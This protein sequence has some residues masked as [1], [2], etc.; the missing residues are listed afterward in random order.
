VC[1]V[2]VDFNSLCVKTGET[3]DRLR[4]EYD[5]GQEESECLICQKTDQGGEP[6]N[7][8]TLRVNQ[9]QIS[10]FDEGNGDV[11]VLLHGWIVTKESFVPMAEALSKRLRIIALDFPGFG[12]SE[13]LSV[14]HTMDKYVS[15]LE[16][17][18]GEIGVE[19][20]H[21]LG[22]S[23]GAAIAFKFALRNNSAVDRLI[24]QAPVFYWGQLSPFFTKGI[25]RNLFRLLGRLNPV[26]RRIKTS[27][28]K[29]LVEERIPR[30]KAHTSDP[31]WDV[32]EPLI[33]ALLTMY[34]EKMVLR[35]FAETA[36]DL[37]NTDLRDELRNLANRTL[38]IWGNEDTTLDPNWG[39]CLSHLLPNSRYVHI[40]G[41]TH[42]LIIE[43][44]PT[45]CE[46]VLAF[47][48]DMP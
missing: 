42:D 27:M 44:Y 43:Q 32:S 28:R 31:L 20:V 8:V 7:S 25:R 41:A 22:T 19:R 39:N 21:L 40:D 38:I 34:D 16:E 4:T 3:T 46:E 35:A 18:L 11:I 5:E 47:L 29:Y 26:R 13:P 30:I 48:D 9:K 37:L 10:Y 15:I 6:M 23:M 45:V 17:F 1:K 36:T 12:D 2:S 33:H 14:T 24:V